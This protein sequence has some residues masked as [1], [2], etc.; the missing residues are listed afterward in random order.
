MQIGKVWDEAEVL[1]F[2]VVP[3]LPTHGP[4]LSS[5]DLDQCFQLDFCGIGHAFHCS[6]WQ[7]LAL[8]GQTWA[9]S[10]STGFLST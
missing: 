9:W 7:A 10:L 2:P 6:V 4:H 3:V 8:W 5:K 1:H